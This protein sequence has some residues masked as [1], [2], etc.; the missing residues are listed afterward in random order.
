M[1]TNVSPD[2][3]SVIFC[4]VC[5]WATGRFAVEEFFAIKRKNNIPKN[6]TTNAT[7]IVTSQN[8]RLDPYILPI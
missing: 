8:L 1:R 4:S 7:I 2:A 3:K 6:T 5:V